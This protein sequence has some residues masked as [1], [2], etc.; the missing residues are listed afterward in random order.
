MVVIDPY[1]TPMQTGASSFGSLYPIALL[2]PTMAVLGI[3]SES[4]GVKS[5]GEENENLIKKRKD[6]NTNFMDIAQ[7]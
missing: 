6:K 4:R 7:R 5:L 1:P 3:S 2:S